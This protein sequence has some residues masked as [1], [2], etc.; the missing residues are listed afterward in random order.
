MHNP[1]T[2]ARSDCAKAFSCCRLVCRL[3]PRDSRRR[4]PTVLLPPT[5][6]EVRQRRRGGWGHGRRRR[7]R[8]G[9]RWPTRRGSTVAAAAHARLAQSYAVCS[10]LLPSR[11]APTHSCNANA[12]DVSC[13]WP[14]LPEPAARR[15]DRI[16]HREQPNNHGQVVMQYR[17]RQRWARLVR[18][19]RALFPTLARFSKTR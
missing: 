3:S 11:H 18:C 14:G 6:A 7:R 10:R 5:D 16:R 2:R 15:V 1:R 4:H 19:T 12:T 9:G 8:G 17:V 13:C